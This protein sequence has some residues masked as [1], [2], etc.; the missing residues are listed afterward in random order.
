MN[1]NIIYKN[2]QKIAEYNSVINLKIDEKKGIMSFLAQ[3]DNKVYFVEII[4]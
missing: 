1:S 2:G 3:R 4:L